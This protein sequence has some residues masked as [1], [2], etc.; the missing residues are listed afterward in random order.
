[1]KARDAVKYMELA[2]PAPPGGRVG[3][4]SP[5]SSLDGGLRGIFSSVMAAA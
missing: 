4:A 5:Q 2:A 1:M 3:G